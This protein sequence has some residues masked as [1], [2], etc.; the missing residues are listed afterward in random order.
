MES[1][2]FKNLNIFLPF[3]IDSLIL[4]AIFFANISDEAAWISGI[5]ENF[6]QAS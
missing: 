6:I 4:D 2:N 5:F 1:K 3:F